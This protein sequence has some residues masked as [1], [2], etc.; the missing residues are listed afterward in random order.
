MNC[1]NHVICKNDVITLGLCVITLYLFGTLNQ[2]KRQNVRHVRKFCWLS[3]LIGSLFSF[4]IT[5]WTTQLAA[6]CLGTFLDCVRFR[7]PLQ[8]APRF[9]SMH[10]D[11]ISC[12]TNFS[13]LLDK[14]QFSWRNCCS[15]CRKV[16]VT[17]TSFFNAG[18]KQK[19]D[20]IKMWQGLMLLEQNPEAQLVLCHKNQYSSEENVKFKLYSTETFIA[21]F[22]L[23]KG[24][25][26]KAIFIPQAYIPST[27]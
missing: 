13:V 5:D 14:V 7:F 4:F 9:V 26:Q 11:S 3:W 8:A 20:K 27:T 23:S 25:F 22:R 10:K 6:W 17:A 1:K 16:S 24:R 2:T 18:W 19:V 12:Y 21:K 15:R